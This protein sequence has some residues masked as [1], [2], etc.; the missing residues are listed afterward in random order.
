MWSGFITLYGHVQD[1][2]SAVS[3]MDIFGISECVLWFGSPDGG[4]IV[5]GGVPS[6]LNMHMHAQSVLLCSASGDPI[7]LLPN[8]K[9]SGC[10]PSVLSVSLSIIYPL[11]LF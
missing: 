1:C 2:S 6:T 4:R 10:D 3:E 9:L 7:C 11:V 8:Y 5:R